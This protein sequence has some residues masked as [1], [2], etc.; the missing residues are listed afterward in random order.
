MA[1]LP[2][3]YPDAPNRPSTSVYKQQ[4][5]VIVICQ[6]EAQQQKA[7]NHLKQFDYSLKLVRT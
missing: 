5:G 3:L 2:P 7:Y 1:K 4:Y 6:S